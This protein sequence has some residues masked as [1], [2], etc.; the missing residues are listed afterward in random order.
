VEFIPEFDDAV[1][2]DDEHLRWGGPEAL[3]A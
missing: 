3:E 2:D 1:L